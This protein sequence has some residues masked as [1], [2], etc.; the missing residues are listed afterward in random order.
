MSIENRKYSKVVKA[1]KRTYFFDLE[2]NKV[3]EKMFL[4]ITESK[5]KNDGFERQEL[6]I[7]IDEVNNF[8]EGLNQT[9]EFYN[10]NIKN[11]KKVTSKIEEYEYF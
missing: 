8:V 9:I 3:D 10:S 7:Y 11:I 4:K 1:G 2:S 6:K 5:S